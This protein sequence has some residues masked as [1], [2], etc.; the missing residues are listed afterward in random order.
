MSINKCPPGRLY[1]FPIDIKLSVTS[2]TYTSAKKIPLNI[3]FNWGQRT[4]AP[5]FS[6][7]GAGIIDHTQSDYSTTVTYNGSLY[8]LGPVQL[9][10]PSHN[11]WLIPK[12]LDATKLDNKEDVIITFQ[13]DMYATKS[14]TD[15]AIIIL[16]NP[17]LRNVSQNGN[18]VY[19]TNMANGVGSPVTLESLYPYISTNDYAYY[20]TCVDG[21]T[22][23]DPFKNILVLLNVQG[24]LVSANLMGKIKDMYNKS[25]QGDY[26]Q[27][28]PLPN[29]RTQNDPKQPVM[30]LREGFQSA[31]VT[32]G[33]TGNSRNAGS[34]ANSRYTVEKCVPFDPETQVNSDGT[35]VLKDGQPQ[36]L[37]SII[38]A[39]T[40]AKT[41]WINTNH[42]GK[43]RLSDIEK[44][45]VY[46]FVGVVGLILIASIFYFV[47][48][49]TVQNVV[50]IVL[51]QIIIG[52][53]CLIGGF[54]IGYYTMPADCPA[55]PPP[56]PPPTPAP[57]LNSSGSP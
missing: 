5:N 48:T 13:R 2:D 11:N 53:G 8:T 23:Q 12:T 54:F 26:P 30:T 29:F 47:M 14:E 17:I 44:G 49:E 24:T 33:N 20:T 28:I 32:T 3:Q 27:Y 7:G 55:S 1:S 34:P 15:P 57:P 42:P 9:A 31:S 16:V 38:D 41:Q 46:T 6:Y 43:Y 21:I 40:S 50:G 4:T 36:T 39:R 35:I 25:S 10:A 19:L 37:Q 45:F 51:N 52:I 18:P 56:P 22:S